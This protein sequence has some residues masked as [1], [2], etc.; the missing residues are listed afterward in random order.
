MIV[1]NVFYLFTE[2]QMIDA[3]QQIEQ[4]KIEL[5]AAKESRRH[6]QGIGS[7]DIHIILLFRI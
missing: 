5:A 4:C 3:K 1:V 6:R 7:F 2:A